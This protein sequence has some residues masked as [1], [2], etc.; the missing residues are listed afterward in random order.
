[1]THTSPKL[2]SNDFETQTNPPTHQK[3]VKKLNVYPRTDHEGTEGELRY[4]CTL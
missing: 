3:K 4:I 2:K 1:M